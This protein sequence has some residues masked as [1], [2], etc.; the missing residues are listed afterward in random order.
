MYL[1]FFGLFLRLKK[2]EYDP[3]PLKER[4]E[5]L[6]CKKHLL[7]NLTVKFDGDKTLWA[8]TYGGGFWGCLGFALK[9]TLSKTRDN[10]T[11]TEVMFSPL[12]LVTILACSVFMF[13]FI[14]VTTSQL[15]NGSKN[16]APYSIFLVFLFV[17]LVVRGQFLKLVGEFL[18]EMTASNARNN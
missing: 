7:A 16:F 6:S 10:V 17:L 13:L 5:V 11:K 15:E 1:P 2:L 18:K 8:R 9:M 4:D 3:F 12:L 14:D